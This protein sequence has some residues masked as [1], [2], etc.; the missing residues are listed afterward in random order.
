VSGFGRDLPGGVVRLA[1][2]IDPTDLAE[3]VVTWAPAKITGWETVVDLLDRAALDL[4]PA[5]LP[6]AEWIEGPGGLGVVAVRSLAHELAAATS[7]HGPFLA[8]LAERA[9]RG[10]AT[11]A[12]FPDPVRIAGL[13]RVIASTS[14]AGE[15]VLLVDAPT[16]WAEPDRDDLM[17]QCQRLSAAGGFR[18]WLRDVARAPDSG[19]TAL[20]RRPAA[21]YFP[22][23]AGAPHHSSLV[24]VALEN[25][26]C[27]HAWSA[28]RQWNQTYRIHTLANPVRPDLLWVE[29]R[30]IV[31]IDGPEHLE[32][33]HFAADRRR[34][35]DL[36]LAGYAV[37]RFTNAEVEH[38]VGAVVSRIGRFVQSRRTAA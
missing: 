12:R 23:S 2:P 22:P 30:L 14:P 16:D 3:A 24:E 7:H 15:M 17:A 29:E 26:L 37:L 5:W 18:V 25:A 9:L 20:P 35:V 32:P 8:D 4:F 33:A 21:P 1:G 19:T 10:C 34:D 11:G 28:G 31:E 13:A 27:R 6:G 38:D 36:Q